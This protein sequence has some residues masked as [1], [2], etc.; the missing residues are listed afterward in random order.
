MKT[1]IDGVGVCVPVDSGA[2]EGG[3]NGRAA[4]FGHESVLFRMERRGFG[5]RRLDAAVEFQNVALGFN[6]AQHGGLVQSLVSASAS[7]YA[8]GY[9]LPATGYFAVC[10]VQCG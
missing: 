3:I 2:V 7:G 10:S 6:P 5:R 9:W 1:A 4:Q 8:S